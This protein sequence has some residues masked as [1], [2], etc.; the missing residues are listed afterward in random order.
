M[1]LKILELMW[2]MI[3]RES[4]FGSKTPSGY[5]ISY[6]AHRMS[7]LHIT[8]G[9][10]WYRW[11]QERGLHGNSFK[12]S[13]KRNI[14]VNSSS[15]RNC[16]STEAIICKRFED[17][18]SEGIRV[19]V[20]ILELKEFVILVEQACNAEELNKE[21]RKADFEARDSRKRPMS[22]SFPSQSKKSK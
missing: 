10:H 2:M 14:L 20:G 13:S 1:G 11:Y 3:L 22:K 19:L 16:V 12:R 21:K 4:S 17:G 18:L 5:L 7:I 9:I 8:G 15:I 6:P